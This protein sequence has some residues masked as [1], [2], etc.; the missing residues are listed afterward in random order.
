MSERFFATT[1]CVTK[2]PDIAALQAGGGSDAAANTHPSIECWPQQHPAL[3]TNPMLVG[4]RQADAM[5]Q[6]NL[7][8]LSG[9]RIGEF[10]IMFFS[11]GNDFSQVS[12]RRF[13]KFSA[14]IPLPPKTALSSPQSTTSERLES[15]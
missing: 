12:L 7:P 15:R 13:C 5:A 14:A 9:Y 2:T 3:A 11:L 4:F 10:R 1:R 6:A 8:H